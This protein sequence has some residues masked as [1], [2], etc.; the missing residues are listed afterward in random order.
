MPAR[1][2]TRNDRR[3]GGARDGTA[4]RR[5][6]AGPARG[7]ARPHPGRACTRLDSVRPAAPPSSGGRDPDPRR[8]SERVGIPLD[9]RFHR[10]R[11]AAVG[12]GADH[13]CGTRHD[14]CDRRAAGARRERRAIR[15]ST[16]VAAANTVEHAP[17]TADVNG[18][19]RDHGDDSRR[20]DS[21]DAVDGQRLDRRAARYLARSRRTA[22]AA[23]HRGPD[24]RAARVGT[25]ARIDHAEAAADDGAHRA[26]DHPAH[27]RVRPSPAAA[28]AAVLRHALPL[29]AMPVPSL[30]AGALSLPDDRAGYWSQQVVRAMGCR[31]HVIVG[32]APCGVVEWAVGELERLE[33]CWSRFRRESELSKLNTTAG[34]GA[35]VDVSAPM[36]LALTCAADLYAATDARFDPTILDALERAGYDRTFEAVAPDGPVARVHPAAGLRHPGFARVEIDVEGS[37]VRLGAGARIDLGGVGKGLAADV[38]ARGLVDRG[39]VSVLVGLGGDLRAR[40]EA[41]AGGAWNV[42]VLDPFDE[43]RTAFALPLHDGAL[44]SSSTR[45]RRWTR[46]GRRYHHLIDP[47]T[48]DSARTGIAAVVTAARDAWWA[49]GIA[50]SIIIA[51]LDVGVRLAREAGVQAWVFLDDGHMLTAG[52]RR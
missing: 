46:A 1:A 4:R 36:L 9:H 3:N 51:G 10:F 35:W 44:V 11:G 24:H 43:S 39:A 13:H 21:A 37:R 40:G 16:T 41:P 52:C 14:A 26:G 45:I 22:R 48:G 42:P 28:P 34:S 47:A 19:T 15:R 31:A 12:R 20:N 18:A 32:D 25:R 27:H 2:R 6:A 50:K 30:I 17:A 33:Q 29:I 8:G 49:E 23:G 38:V 5:R 7:P